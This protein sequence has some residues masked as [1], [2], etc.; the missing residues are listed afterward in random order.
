MASHPTPA[1]YCFRHHR[2]A[3]ITTTYR[4]K[5]SSSL[6]RRCQNYCDRNCLCHH[7]PNPAIHCRRGCHR[8]RHRHSAIHYHGRRRHRCHSI[9][10]TYINKQ[11]TEYPS[12]NLYS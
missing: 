7:Y 4:N 10:I 3:A 5:I 11:A 12:L 1:L 9:S 6:R 8:R 2:C